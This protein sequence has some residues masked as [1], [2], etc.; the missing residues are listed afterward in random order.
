MLP[1]D[2][3]GLVGIPFLSGAASDSD[4]TFTEAFPKSINIKSK[5]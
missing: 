5:P 4:S 3:Y 1:F 2:E